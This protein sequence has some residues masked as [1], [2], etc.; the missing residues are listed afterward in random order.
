MKAILQCIALVFAVAAAIAV[1]L[2][3]IATFMPIT[4]GVY[5]LLIGAVM[6]AVGAYAISTFLSNER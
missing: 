3:V 1:A 2:I 4:D 6:L 5:L